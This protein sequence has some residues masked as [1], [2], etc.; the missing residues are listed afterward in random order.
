ML[1]QL[2]FAAAQA[3]PIFIFSGSFLPLLADA[4]CLLKHDQYKQ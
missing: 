2:E 1:V 3:P 4:A